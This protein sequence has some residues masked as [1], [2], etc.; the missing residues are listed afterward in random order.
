MAWAQGRGERA[1]LVWRLG[2]GA[3]AGMLAALLAALFLAWLSILPKGPP[4]AL[5]AGADNSAA[6][7]GI[8]RYVETSEKI[9]AFTF[10]DG[11]GPETASIVAAFQGAGGHA[12]FFVMGRL[13]ERR[14]Q[15][16][17]LEAAA[18]DEIGNHSYSHSWVTRLGPGQLRDEL[19]RTDAIVRRATGRD[20]DLFRFPGFIWTPGYVRLVQGM[21]YRVVAGSVDPKDWT[22]A[23][24]GTIASR[25][26]E[27]VFPGAI[28]VMHDGPEG[29]GATVRALDTILPRLAAEGY[30]FVTVSELLER[31]SR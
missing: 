31:G 8:F 3:R 6:A 2:R 18:G 1:V 4:A 10:D 27:G 14:T 28:V 21:G 24:A 30:R 26:L 9:V 5:G 20:V 22:R 23:G 16:L 7:L 25:V 19:G 29:R 13:A 15:D 12:T 11:P 17:V